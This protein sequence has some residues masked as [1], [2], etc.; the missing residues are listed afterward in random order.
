MEFSRAAHEV[1]L[2]GKAYAGVLTDVEVGH[3]HTVHYAKASVAELAESVL[4][5]LC[6]VVGGSTLSRHSPY[7]YW[8]QDV[9]ALGFLRP[10]WS[11]AYDVLY[12]EALGKDRTQE[13]R[14]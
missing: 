12:D 1:W 8:A 14:S 10:P 13:E 9:K 7:G 4:T 6:R 5:R 11:L 3:P 2:L